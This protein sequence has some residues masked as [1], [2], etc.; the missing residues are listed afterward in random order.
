MDP[1]SIRPDEGD[2]EAGRVVDE[3]AWQARWSNAST[4]DHRPI[5][6]LDNSTA[7]V[8]D[9]VGFLIHQDNPSTSN[10]FAS[11]HREPDP[12]Q[13]EDHPGESNQHRDFTQH[14]E[15]ILLD[16]ATIEAQEAAMAYLDLT[17]PQPLRK[18]LRWSDN[19]TLRDVDLERG[20]LV[21]QY[22]HDAE[23]K[24]SA[25]R[26]FQCSQTA[27]HGAVFQLS[28]RP[29]HTRKETESSVES[30]TWTLTE[31]ELEKAATFSNAKPKDY[32]LPAQRLPQPLRL[33]FYSFFSVYRILFCMAFMPNVAVIL[34]L[35]IKH[36]GWTGIPLTTIGTAVGANFTLAVI[37]RQEHVVN[38]LFTI[39]AKTPHFVPLQIRHWIAKVYS[40]G[41][42]HSGAGIA[43]LFWFLLFTVLATR[44]V[45]VGSPSQL[46]HAWALLALTYVIIVLFF[47]LVIFAHPTLRVK[48]HD[49]F[50]NTHR[51][52]GW[53]IL[54][55]FWAHTILFAA[56]LTPPSS[57]L[58]RTLSTTPLFYFLMIS[59]TS[60]II[61][62]LRLRRVPVTAE[63]LSSHAIRLHFSH[64]DA[65]SGAAVRLSTSPL[66]EWHAFAT[67]RNTPRK[68]SSSQ[69][70]YSVL[71]SNAGDWTSSI[72]TNP[73]SSLYVRGIV[74]KGVIAIA[75]LFRR[76][77]LICT[78]SGVGPILSL[79]HKNTISAR[80]LWSTP[81][82]EQTFGKEIVDDVLRYDEK[83]MI[84]NTR[85]PGMRRPDL[86]RLAYN[87]YRESGAEAVFI[88]SNARVTR[89][90]VFGLESRGVPIFAPVFDS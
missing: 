17:R 42:L 60:I 9:T 84:I 70:G 63:R 55:L 77:V 32:E 12:N 61:P 23:S 4:V 73:P 56:T 3:M 57:T 37:M 83:A 64:E 36:Q 38:A 14:R 48:F 88:I 44:G 39:F 47:I 22:K 53:T 25:N 65:K 26:Q 51:F 2:L 68:A 30:T 81:H 75:P 28:A 34:T 54:A 79:L 7:P 15:S 74:T 80:I 76:S 89:E 69:K 90:V 49:H 40:F 41:G 13:Q 1:N 58:A 62:W 29:D 5:S 87:L 35:L 85:E 8:V 11:Q 46:N 18:K 86:G 10:G 27:L 82:P 20:D 52:I 66:K 43:A 45:L 50:E 19:S 78:G 71:V 31:L 59:T 16:N 33:L 24:P 72:I 67:I 21:P 6:G